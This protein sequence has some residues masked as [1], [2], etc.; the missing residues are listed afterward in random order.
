MSITF[1][2]TMHN[3]SAKLQAL[4]LLEYA[5]YLIIGITLDFN[6]SEDSPVDVEHLNSIYQRHMSEC[7]YSK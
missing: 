7:R 5:P 1:V 4:G 3:N 2:R 6:G